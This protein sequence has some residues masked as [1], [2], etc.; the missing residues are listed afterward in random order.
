MQEIVCLQSAHTERHRVRAE[1]LGHLGMRQQVQAAALV[2]APAARRRQP[3]GRVAPEQPVGVGLQQITALGRRYRRHEARVLFGEEPLHAVQEPV[4]LGA[5]AQEDAAQ[6]E[7]GATLRM[8]LAVRQCQ[9]RAPGAAKHQ[10]LRDA[11]PSAQA[12]DV[13]HQQLGRVVAAFAQGCRLAGAALVKQHDPVVRRIEELPVPGRQSGARAAMQEQHRDAQRIAAL[14][15]VQGVQVVHRQ[16]AA[17]VRLD[18]WIQGVGKDRVGHGGACPWVRCS[19]CS[20]SAGMAPAPA[21]A[22][23][24]APAVTGTALA[25]QNI[26]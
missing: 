4:D 23:A 20:R 8:A 11:Q 19:Q 2:A 26:E 22:I 13:L 15:P 16:H 10:P 12:L 7:A 5:A 17:A 24:L 9:G 18:R 3:S 1:L 21:L 14:L 25:W 6:D